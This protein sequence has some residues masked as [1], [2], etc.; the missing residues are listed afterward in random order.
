MVSFR[1]AKLWT[2]PLSLAGSLGAAARFAGG[3]RAY[4]GAWVRTPSGVVAT[5]SVFT[6]RG[7]LPGSRTHDESKRRFVG[8]TAICSGPPSMTGGLELSIISPCRS[9]VVSAV[10]ARVGLPGSV[11]AVVQGRTV[12]N[13]AKKECLFLTNKAVILL[14]TKG[15]ENE[16]SRTN[17]FPA[18]AASVF[19]RRWLLPGP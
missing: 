12:T 14:K 13:S 9:T 16:Q 7:L 3:C 5:A 6:R 17:P 2:E 19:T 4:M 10:V 15:W 8:A 11:G 1:F 18:A